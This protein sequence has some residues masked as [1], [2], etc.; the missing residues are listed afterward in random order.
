[1]QVNTYLARKSFTV[2]D[3]L[4]I[5]TDIIYIS[6]SARIMNG[7]IDYGRKIFDS[8]KNYLGQIS[9]KYFDEDIKRFLEPYN[10]E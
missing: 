8:D 10:E 2:L 4:F 9:E 7:I 5:K 3:K 6:N 1:M